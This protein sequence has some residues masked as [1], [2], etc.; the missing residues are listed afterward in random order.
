MSIGA[1]RVTATYVPRGSRVAD[2]LTLAWGH[3]TMR[4]ADTVVG[5][6]R[7]FA[8]WSRCG[9]AIVI[10]YDYTHADGYTEPCGSYVVSVWAAEQGPPNR[11]SAGYPACSCGAA[12]VPG[13]VAGVKLKPRQ[14]FCV[15]EQRTVDVGPDVALRARA[16]GKA[17]IESR[18]RLP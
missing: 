17:E 6:L 2:G 12:L 15:R 18:G 10:D 11:P 7:D 1:Y 3:L 9:G 5:R 4:G 16:Q 13:D 14:L 8:R